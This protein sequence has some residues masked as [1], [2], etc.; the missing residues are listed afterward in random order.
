MKKPVFFTLLLLLT[1]LLLTA[2]NTYTYDGATAYRTASGELALE[3]DDVQALDVDWVAGSVT[4]EAWE[5]DTVRVVENAKVSLSAGDKLRYRID[6]KT[7][8][9]RYMQ[10]SVLSADLIAKD[11]LIQIPASL[12]L[13]ELELDTDSANAEIKDLSCTRYALESISGDITVASVGSVQVLEL[14]TVSGASRLTFEALSHFEIDTF[15]GDVKLACQEAPGDG[16]IATVSGDVELVLP[17]ESGFTVE[18]Q[19]TSGVLTS[20]LP[21]TVSEKRYVY[22][23]GDSRYQIETA[24]ANV[25]IKKMEKMS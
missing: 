15:N 1:A 10:E 5:G 21:L 3:T 22:G 18:F 16:E 17:E 23:T 7:L 11:L 20:D 24:T 8:R 12:L 9:I 25:H 6:G 14:D 4:V 13:T 2:C 19:S